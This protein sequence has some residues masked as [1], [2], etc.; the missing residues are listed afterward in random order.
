MRTRLPFTGSA[1]IGVF[2]SGVGGL[3]VLRE[4]R[5]LLPTENL[6][7]VAD[8]AHVPYGEKSREFVEQRAVAISGFL[9]AQGAK[10]IVVAC[11]TATSAAIVTLR[12]RFAV[13]I[14]GVEPALKPAAEVTRSG[15][16]GVL[17][18]TGTLHGAKFHQLQ[19]R[20]AANV[21]VLMQ[22]CEGW[23]EQVE[24]GDLTGP[25]A[26]AL[27]E[28]QVLSLIERGADTLVLGCTHYPFLVPLIREVA[29]PD[30]HVIDPSQAVARELKRRMESAN[31]LSAA[32][33]NGSENFWTTGDPERVGRV[34][35]VLWGRECEVGKIL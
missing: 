12:V 24:T 19:E 31:L 6:I 10:V 4:I 15:T 8:S 33:E 17:A 22:A 34:I 5:R 32:G 28:R 21:Q 13:P 30:V 3:S 23:V 2:D 16:V 26:R 9:I 35:S 1:P 7:Y 25:K 27:V 20:F 29:G 11:N 18:T 14:V